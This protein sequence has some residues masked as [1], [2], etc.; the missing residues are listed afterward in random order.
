[1]NSEWLIELGG[2][3]QATIRITTTDQL[4][5]G[6]PLALLTRQQLRYELSPR[7]L[8]MTAELGLDVHYEPLSEMTVTL[9]TPLQ[10][11]SAR[12]EDRELEW[13]AE[14]TDDAAAREVTL[15]FPQPVIGSGRKIR[16]TCIAPIVWDQRWRLPA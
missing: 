9:A 8:Q 1:A 12:N 7:G 14:F 16:L 4:E 2:Y 3:S 15:R 5:R 13:N 10:L 11:I 6:R